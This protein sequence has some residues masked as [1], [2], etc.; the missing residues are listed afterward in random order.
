MVSQP[1]STPSDWVAE[2]RLV[3]SRLFRLSLIVNSNTF[4]QEST[5]SPS[6][7]R[8]PHP[9]RCR[10]RLRPRRECDRCSHRS[11]S[12]PHPASAR[13]NLRCHHLHHSS[14]SVRLP[15][16][17]W[18]KRYVHSP[19]GFQINSTRGKP[20]RTTITKNR[21]DFIISRVSFERNILILG[22]NRGVVLR[23][24]HAIHS[25]W[26]PRNK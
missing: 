21:R 18:T 2:D 15:L 8:V 22:S 13:R 7:R 14:K 11:R 6:Y 25:P 4:I 10:I 19:F 24:R 20:R 12:A 26:S 16:A 5:V 1:T 23:I 9:T 3:R 17:K